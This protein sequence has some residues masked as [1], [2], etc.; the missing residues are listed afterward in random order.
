M[1]VGLDVQGA[2]DEVAHVLGGT[3][4]RTGV[5]SGVGALSAGGKTIKF[6]YGRTIDPQS[7]GEDGVCAI[8]F[9]GGTQ[10]LGGSGNLYAYTH[11]LRAHLCVSVLR[12]NFHEADAIL[13]PFIP[14]VR[15]AL[16]AATQLNGK[17]DTSELE[18]ISDIVDSMYK[19]RLAIDFV[20]RV[21][22]KEAVTVAA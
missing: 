16:A 2:R 5:Y 15:N 18:G 10:I 22:Q 14:V 9:F 13:T 1:S 20:L 6:A 17:A 3:L 8:V 21:T 7:L 4:L 12:S 19:N 11:R